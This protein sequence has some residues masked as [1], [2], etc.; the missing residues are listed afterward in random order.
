MEI[1]I[2]TEWIEGHEKKQYQED[3]DKPGPGKKIEKNSG[4]I[5]F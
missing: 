3:R 4:L 5:Q 2:K 1:Y